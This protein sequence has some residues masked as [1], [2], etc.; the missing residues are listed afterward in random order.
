[1]HLYFVL[2]GTF[3]CCL[4]AAKQLLQHFP[5]LLFPQLFIST[6]FH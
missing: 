6:A 4:F 5:D 2:M 3:W 1:M